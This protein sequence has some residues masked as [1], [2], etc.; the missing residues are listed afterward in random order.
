MASG[1]PDKVVQDQEEQEKFENELYR[2]LKTSC[3]AGIILR[4]IGW[5]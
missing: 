3:E 4:V 1:S 2:I 5:K